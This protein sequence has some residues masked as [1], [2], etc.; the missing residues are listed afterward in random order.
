MTV[1]V[2]N[3][4][5]IRASAAY[6]AVVRIF[7]MSYW[8]CKC[9]LRSEPW[10]LAAWHHDNVGNHNII[11]ASVAYFAVVHIFVMSNR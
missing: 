1:K 9:I 10:F 4:K 11:R 8:Y 6:F 5:F 7:V 2:S 3:N